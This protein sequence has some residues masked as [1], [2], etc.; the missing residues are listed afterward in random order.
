MSVRPILFSAPMV[1]AIIAGRKLQTRRIAKRQDRPGYEVGDLLWVREA[2]RMSLPCDT[3]DRSWRGGPRS[4]PLYRADPDCDFMKKGWKPGVHMPRAASRIT[5][6]VTKVRVQRLQEI[7][8][9]DAQAEGAARLVMDDEHKFYESEIGTYRCGF[10]G[11]WNHIN[12][13]RD[14][15]DWD[16]N[17]WIVALTFVVHP[18]NVDA[19]L[20]QHPEAA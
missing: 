16:S 1:R 11:L 5:L 19:Y 15:A 20:A 17:P 10:A 9:A 3:S 4:A 6:A 2:W 18:I 12:G 14:G 8:E 13:R 7:S